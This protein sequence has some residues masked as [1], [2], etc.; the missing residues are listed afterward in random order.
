MK[1]TVRCSSRLHFGLLSFGISGIRQFGGVG[2]MIEHPCVELEA[3]PSEQGLASGFE[4]ERVSHVANHALNYLARQGQQSVSA[5][6]I[7]VRHSPPAHVGLGSGT[8][9]GLA[10][11]RAVSEL[12]NKQSVGIN[13]LARMADRGRRSSGGTHGFFRGGLIVESGTVEESS[14]APLLSRVAVPDAWRVVLAIP[15]FAQG[16]SG[17]RQEQAFR[18]MGPISIETTGK[19]CR[20][21]ML[22][23][24]PSLIESDFRTFSESVYQFNREVGECFSMWQGG[25]YS[26][27][28]VERAIQYF[29]S[30]GVQGVGQSSWGPTVFGIV[31]TNADAD[32]LRVGFKKFFPE[33]AFQVSVSRFCN[34]GAEVTV[35]NS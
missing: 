25:P 32:T 7:H 20:Q 21:V 15:T 31:E 3:L 12:C 19:L 10:V 13:E 6:A 1:V 2:A 9:L 30:E 33:K 16:I 26:S 22:N 34:Q 35:V 11:A 28:Q 24:L 17:K 18:N 23:L 29:R 8:Q 27:K 5:L 14:I 4:S